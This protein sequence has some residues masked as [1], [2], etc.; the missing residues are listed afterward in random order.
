MFKGMLG[1][2]SPEEVRMYNA[3]HVTVKED[4]HI[5]MCD[6]NKDWAFKYST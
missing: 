5:R 6:E 1:F 3:V 4:V 2:L